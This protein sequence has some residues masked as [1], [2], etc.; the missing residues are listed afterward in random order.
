[1]FVVRRLH[2]EFYHDSKIIPLNYINN[3]LGGN[4]KFYSNLTIRNKTINSL[5]SDYK[6][7][8]D[9]WCKYYSCSPEVPSLVS[10][11][12]LCYSTYIKIDNEAICYKDFADK[13]INHV[14]NLFDEN[15]ELK[16][17]Q[18]ILSNL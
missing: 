3:N 17:W 6:Y 4:F 12:F 16:S 8:I 1:M 15:G 7:I 2:N 18:K 5:L 14:S 9:S 10:S 11:Q 13:N